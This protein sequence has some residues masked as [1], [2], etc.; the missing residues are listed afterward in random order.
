[1]VKKAAKCS[2]CGAAL[3]TELCAEEKAEEAD[4]KIIQCDIEAKTEK[5]MAAQSELMDRIAELET[6]L[7]K[8]PTVLQS[9][10]FFSLAHPSALVGESRDIPPTKLAVFYFPD[11]H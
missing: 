11:A 3:K 4:A 9:V 10:G 7:A 2:G 1:M 8:E 5:M 6:A